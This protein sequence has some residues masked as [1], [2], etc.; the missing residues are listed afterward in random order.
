M[1]RIVCSRCDTLVSFDDVTPGYW[2]YCPQ[3]D[4][5]LFMIE[6]EIKLVEVAV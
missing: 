6:C 2:A 1:N 5:D 3:H 4:E